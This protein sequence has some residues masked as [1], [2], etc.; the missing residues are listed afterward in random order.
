MTAEDL[1]KQI[2]RLKDWSD[3]RVGPWI[4]AVF[5]VALLHGLARLASEFHWT[6]ELAVTLLFAFFAAS[7]LL[8]WKRKL[9][10]GKYPTA[11]LFGLWLC[12]L[13]VAIE[14]FASLS[15][16]LTAY[17][18][19]AFKG[20]APPTRDVF[21]NFYSYHFVDSLPGLKLWDTFSIPT[22]PYRQQTFAAGV[23]LLIFRTM[24]LA[25][26]LGALKDWISSKRKAPAEAQPASS[27]K[28]D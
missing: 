15:A 27:A 12:T 26:I 3:Q 1:T 6:A 16:M 4:G 25:T 10:V 21:V 8:G 28:P 19:G 24:V 2:D 5:F 22:F 9:Y 11:T 13:I 7:L 23:L 14:V 17:Q 18:P 20:P